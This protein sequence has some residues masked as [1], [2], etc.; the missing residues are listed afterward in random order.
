MASTSAPWM[1]GVQPGP[2]D[3]RVR[4]SMHAADFYQDVLGLVTERAHGGDI[5]V[6]SHSSLLVRLLPAET[7]PTA[8]HIRPG[9]YHMALLL[10]D[11]IAL[12]RAL[13]RLLSS[14]HPLQGAADHGVSQALYLADPEGNGIELYAD[15]PRSA[16]PRQGDTLV[17]GTDRLDLNTLLREAHDAP[18]GSSPL[19]NARMGHIHLRVSDLDAACNFYV[20]RLGLALT[21]RLGQ[22]AAFFSADGYHHHL[23]ANTWETA[24]A[25]P[26]E[27]GDP[28]LQAFSLTLA[29]AEKAAEAARRIG[30]TPQGSSFF[31]KDPSGIGLRLTAAAG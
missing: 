27:Q 4:N 17:M 25:P 16:W 28:G 21:Q 18:S 11:S 29:D 24:G 31:A 23:G 10:E 8:A 2:V 26:A 20:E 9:L 12:G 22:D 30:A 14:G 19:R 3:L 13:E 5:E 6:R 1:A 7:I 15:R